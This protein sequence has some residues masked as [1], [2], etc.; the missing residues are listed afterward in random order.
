VAT[1]THLDSE[2]ELCPKHFR[3]IEIEDQLAELSA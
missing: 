2:R 3:L 1:I